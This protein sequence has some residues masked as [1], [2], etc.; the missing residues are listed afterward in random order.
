MNTII[1]ILLLTSAAL[2]VS[3]TCHGQRYR[4]QKTPQK[5]IEPSYYENEVTQQSFVFDKG[6]EN[7]EKI[8]WFVVADR[9]GVIARE[10]PNESASQRS[11]LDYMRYYYVVD[12]DGQWIKLV[13]GP[14]PKSNG[15]WSSPVKE[16]GWVRKD[17]VLLWQGSLRNEGAN[18]HMKGFI[19]NKVSNIGKILEEGSKDFANVYNGPKTDKASKQLRFY[20]LYFIY[21]VE[22]GRMLLGKDY[23]LGRN[24]IKDNLVGWVEESKVDKWFTRIALEP[25][26]DEEAFAERKSKKDNN[27]VIGFR[28]VSNAVSYLKSGNIS[29]DQIVWDNDPVL[30]KIEFLSMENPRRYK[31][32]VY[33]FPMLNLDNVANRK[34]YKSGTI[35]Q[36]TTRTAK[37]FGVQASLSERDPLLDATQSDDVLDRARDERDNVNVF[38]VIE[39]IPSTKPYTDVLASTISSINSVFSNS[40]NVRVGAAFYIDSNEKA[41]GKD[42]RIL[43]LTTDHYSIRQAITGSSYTKVSDFDDYNALYHA[44]YKSMIKGGFSANATNVMIVIGEN[45]DISTSRKRVLANATDKAYFIEPAQLRRELSTYNPHLLFIQTQTEDKKAQRRYLSSNRDLIQEVTYDVFNG[46]HNGMIQLYGKRYEESTPTPE[47]PQVQQGELCVL[48]MGTAKSRI[49]S[50]PSGQSIEKTVLLTELRDGLNA[51]NEDISETYEDFAEIVN[52]GASIEDVSSGVW[53]PSLCR[54]LYNNLSKTKTSDAS[55]Q[56]QLRRIV[57]E[58]F[59]LFNVVYLPQK[60]HDMQTP[61]YKFVLFMPER[62]LREHI[63]ALEELS[64]SG[65]GPVS[66]QRLALFESV[67][68]LVETYSGEK[69]R[70][71]DVKEM[72]FN[73]VRALMQGISEQG[74]FIGD[75]INDQIGINQINDIMDEKIVSDSRFE[76]IQKIFIE[77]RKRLET[78]LSQGDKYEFAYGSS[79]DGGSLYFWIPAE[80]LM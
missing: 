20:D 26:F 73:E 12:D 57:D 7:K 21:K 19:L 51:V 48:K 50:P 68:S 75:V 37:A 49:I 64:R 76:G 56:E 11:T 38:L 52:E 67:K 45:A 1:K 25:N 61:L 60:A 47:M 55:F 72:T 23:F 30:E 8:W 78:I 17:E 24:E 28:K 70:A 46:F 58:K 14:Q 16:K 63:R 33:R 15:K 3:S 29:K 5:F 66:E 62:D 35:G 69:V 27:R 44:M 43:P 59:R 71:K 42:L 79:K 77:K 13:E 36:V 9:E 2:V 41:N 80:H 22:N 74:Y 31:G 40:S 34:Y 65:N 10:K 54:L 4:A 53:E 39:D 32:G 18:I 6:A